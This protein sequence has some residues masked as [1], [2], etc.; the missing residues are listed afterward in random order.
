MP[1]S[2]LE[3][4]K[5]LTMAFIERGNLRPE[6]M[7]DTLLKTHASLLTLKAQE[8]FGT[9]AVPVGTAAPVNWRKSITKH[10]V[11]C[12]ECGKP[13]KQL[14]TRHLMLHG[15]DG[16]SY[17]AK[18]GIP[19]TQPLA[20]KETT[21]RRRQI[22]AELKPWEKAPAYVKAQERDGNTAPTPEA[23]APTRKRTPPTRQR[24]AAR[25]KRSEG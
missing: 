4:A 24:K 18:Y 19:R 5:E 14:S 15:L 3:I 12:L 11:S 10:A 22:M 6:D 20:A 17:R 9:T 7:Q 8:S 1:Q 25:K 16:R 21:A 2:V 23:E 13:F